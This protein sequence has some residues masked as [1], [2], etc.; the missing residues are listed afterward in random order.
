MLRELGLDPASD[1]ALHALE[2]VCDK[3]TWKGCGPEE[4][5]QNLLFAGEVEPCING[6]VAASSAYFG[7]DVQG[8][9][10]R[11]QTLRNWKTC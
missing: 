11:N 1:A 7:Q 4:C 3:V 6:Q 10:N 5:D 8:I 9:M 2:L